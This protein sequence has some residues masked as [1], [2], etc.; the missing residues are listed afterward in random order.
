MATT[1]PAAKTD[2]ATADASAHRIQRAPR[3]ELKRLI[4]ATR[5]SLRGIRATWA[6]EAAFRSELIALVISLPAGA[7]LAETMVHFVLLEITLLILIMAEL[8]NTAIERGMDRVGTEHH[9]LTGEAKDIASAAVMVAFLIVGL[10][11][12]AAIAVKI[13]QT[14]SLI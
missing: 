3:N 4:Y 2:P 11:W 5:N 10:A 8:L 9:P 1:D 7:W 13:N 6:T 12:G 14:W